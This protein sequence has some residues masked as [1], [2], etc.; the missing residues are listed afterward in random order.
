M[1]SPEGTRSKPRSMIA[2]TECRRRRVKCVTN[3]IPPVTPCARCV[4]RQ[5]ACEYVAT[6]DGAEEQYIPQQNTASSSSSVAAALPSE[7]PMQQDFPHYPAP[8]RGRSASRHSTHRTMPAMYGQH[9]HGQPGLLRPSP[10]PHAYDIQILHAQE[11]L[12]KRAASAA[13]AQSQSHVGSHGGGGAGYGAAPSSFQVED[14]PG[15]VPGGGGGG[16]P[17]VFDLGEWT[18]K[19]R[20]CGMC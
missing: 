2:C 20:S 11:Y 8:A 1:S 16:G 7:T 18:L 19:I 4:K 3:E 9:A 5:L 10:N 13:Q 15:H 12:R 14:V 17:Q 6:Q